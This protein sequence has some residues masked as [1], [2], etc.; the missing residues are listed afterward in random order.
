MSSS[1]PLKAVR[2]LL[3]TYLQNRAEFYAALLPRI[4]D[5]RQRMAFEAAAASNESPQALIAAA[6]SLPD[7]A[8]DDDLLP[9]LGLRDALKKAGFGNA[10]GRTA[11]STVEALRRAQSMEETGVLL[12]DYLQAAYPSL[13]DVFHAELLRRRAALAALL[14]L[15]DSLRYHRFPPSPQ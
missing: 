3:R 15:E 1:Q 14:R 9:A 12:F 4:P 5:A 11:V 10:F 2:E 7:I 8:S 6:E 13:T